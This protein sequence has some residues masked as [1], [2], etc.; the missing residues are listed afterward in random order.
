MPARGY[1]LLFSH[2]RSHSTLLAHILGSHPEIDGYTELHQHYES[3]IDLRNMTRRIE[4]HTGARRRGRYAFDKLL[5][6]MAIVDGAILRR[7]DVKVVFLLRNARDTIP[8]IIRAGRF[9]GKIL[10]AGTPEGA[11]HYYVTRLERMDAY[12]ELVGP[13]AAFVE[14]EKLISDTDAVLGGLTRFL[15]LET[16]LSPNYEQFKHTGQRGLGDMGPNIL[17]G[18]VLRD[19]ERDRSGEQVEVPDALMAQAIAAHEALLPKLRARHPQR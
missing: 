5:H 17:S 8:S 6:N 10:T 2:M 14:A 9:D 19:E 4:E 3:P 12:S 16:P 7:D 13:R 1:V 18:R 11:T 15:E